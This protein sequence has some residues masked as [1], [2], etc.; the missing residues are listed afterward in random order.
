MVKNLRVRV[1]GGGVGFW[2]FLFSLAVHGVL[3]LVFSFVHVSGG[4]SEAGLNEPSVVSVT[5]IRKAVSLSPVVAKPMV[6]RVDVGDLGG[7]K[8]LDLDAG[9]REKAEYFEGYTSATSGQLEGNLLAGQFAS[10]PSTDFFGSTTSLRK[11]CYV[12]DASG[13]MQGRLGMVRRQLKKSI[14]KLE[15]DQY[16]Y[17][18]FFR[19]DGLVESGKGV[20]VRATVS[21]KSRAYKF[22]DSVRFEGPTNAA[23][24][25]KRAMKIKGVGRE[26]AQQIYFLSDGF[27]LGAGESSDFAGMVEKMRKKLAPSVR[28][29]TIGIWVEQEDEKILRAIASGSGGEYVGIE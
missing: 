10:G 5:Q 22:V 12:V 9:E 7:K 28:I 13:S 27:D 6:K 24:A 18:I 3:F 21:A 11:I 15:A 8:G 2:A 16:F 20:L 23:N 25:I 19:G 17:I 26:S 29:N 14:A 4:S 1:I